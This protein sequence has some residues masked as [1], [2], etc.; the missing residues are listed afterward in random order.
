M[1]PKLNI[2]SSFKSLDVAYFREGSIIACV[3]I[4]YNLEEANSTA[5]FCDRFNDTI[6]GLISE[7]NI[8]NIQVNGEYL[9]CFRP[10]IDGVSIYPVLCC[11]SYF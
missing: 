10:P 7:V 2:N 9:S 1:I 8:T 4:T 6:E 11:F 3:V 5:D